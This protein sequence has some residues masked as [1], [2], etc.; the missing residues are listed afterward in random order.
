[1]YKATIQ[2]VDGRIHFVSAGTQDM[3]KSKLKQFISEKDAEI[4]TVE[5]VISMGYVKHPNSL[6]VD[7]NK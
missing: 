7:Y 2:Y 6:F 5:K 3:L 1:M 4:I